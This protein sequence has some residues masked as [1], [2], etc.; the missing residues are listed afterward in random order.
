MTVQTTLCPIPKTTM[1]SAIFSPCRKYR[2]ALYREWNPSK[3]LLM[4][5]GLNPST[6]DEIQDDPTIRRCIDFAKRWNY[7]QLIMMNLFAIRGTDPKI[8][9]DVPDPIGEENDKYLKEMGEKASLILGAWGSH[10]IYQNRGKKVRSMFKLVHILGLTKNG[11]PKHPL[12]LKKET[13]IQE[14][15]MD[16]STC[17]YNKYGPYSDQCIDCDEDFNDKWKGK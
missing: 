1:P 9:K 11:Q 16:C 2:Y 7:G 14:W 5:I 12:Y 6:A 13:T 8:I 17:R 4:I 3:P 15:I 10:G